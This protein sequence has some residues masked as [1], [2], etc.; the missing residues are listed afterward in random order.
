MKRL[1]LCL[2]LLHAL[3]AGFAQ[4][5]NP[6]VRKVYVIF[7]THL[8]IGFTE[9]SSKVEQ[10]YI[11]EF[12]PKAIAVADELRAAG[13]E[14]RYVWTTGAWL[15]DAYLRQAR[16]EAVRQLEN[17]IR[18]GDIA[19]NAMPYTVESE[20]MNRELF[21]GI[22]KLSHRLD[23]RFGKKTVAA[24]MTDV[25]GH[26]RSIVPLL[27]DAGISFLHIGVN[28]AATVPDVP[29][30][31]RW[32]DARNRE[33]ILMYQ[34]SYGEEMV[35][36]DG[37]T[38]LSINF[39]NDNKGPH[40]V[41]RVKNIYAELHRRYPNAVVE[42]SSLDAV[43][44]ELERMRGQLPVLTSEIGDTWIYGYGSS[45]LR[46]ARFRE[47]SRLYARWIREGELAFD[48]DAA[49][50]F[51]IRLGMIAE[52]TWGAD[53]KVF[54]KN[55]D[56]YDYDAFSAA[57]ALP[58][59]RYVERSWQELDD[60]VDKAVALL[61]EPLRTEAARAVEAIGRVECAPLTHA[62]RDRR[63]DARGRYRLSVRGLKCL[64]GGV[65]YQ[66]FSAEDYDRFHDAYLTR[67]VQWALEDNGKPG[68]ERTS[69]RSVLLEA[70]AERCETTDTPEGRRIS[71]DL[72]FPADGRIDP[73]VLPELVRAEYRPA[74]DGRR[75]E[76]TLTL[77]GKPANR[78]PEAYWLSFRPENLLGVVAEKTGSPV[79]LLDVVAGGNRQMHGIDRYVDLRTS[80]G[81]LRITSLDAL[82]LA[83]GERNALNYS[84]EMPD[85]TQGVHF[86]LYNNLWGTNFS[87][88]WEGSIRYRFL[89]ELL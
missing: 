84:T 31:C 25:P 70:Q 13:G 80:K 87:M 17:A 85:L 34:K 33:I 56:K 61:P 32:R 49:V 14:E 55:W 30:V 23:E 9:F 64:L 43:A 6:D 74:A 35:L 21:S 1:F 65:A 78:M 41:Q 89:I 11:D 75:I 42:A 72:R 7:K 58:P 73:R 52:H 44:R 67:R 50:E 82:L 29:P 77:Q 3:H 71:C 47:L 86:C 88:W 15:V 12:I 59:F 16:P 5:P 79:D 22:M 18:R 69:A 54:L 26:T 40:T 48:S 24:K 62:G 68:L 8:D 10:R 46:M 51:A 60:N 38:V 63:V 76:M 36:P 20:S 81:T 28:S 37:E 57:R 4:E 39:T 66:T 83:V 2:C 45:P 19:W 27:S 53:V